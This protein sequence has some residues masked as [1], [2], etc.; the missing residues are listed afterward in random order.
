MVVLVS[1]LC[2]SATVPGHDDSGRGGP[3]RVDRLGVEVESTDLVDTAAQ[4]LA[5]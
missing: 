1:V 2:R 4:R 3:S 5:G